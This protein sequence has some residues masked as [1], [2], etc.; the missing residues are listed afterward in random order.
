MI[1]Q[2]EEW[3]GRGFSAIRKIYYINVITQISNRKAV[4]WNIA[5]R[6]KRRNKI[7]GYLKGGI[8][9]LNDEEVTEKNEFSGYRIIRIVSIGDKAY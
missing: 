4:A 1:I 8:S 2:F 7:E 9:G 6:L 5:G 3:I